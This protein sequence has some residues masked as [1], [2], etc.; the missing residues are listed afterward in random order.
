MAKAKAP[1]TLLSSAHAALLRG[2]NVGGKNKLPMKDL[3]ALFTDAGCSDVQTYIQSG[4]VV[5]RAPESGLPGLSSTIEKG[6]FDRF[7]F[8][9]PVIVRAGEILFEVNRNNPFLREGKDPQTLHVAF[10]S[11]LPDATRVDK[12][13]QNRSSPDTFFVLGQHI[14]LCLPNGVA[15]TKLTNDYFDRTLG[16]ISTVRNFRTVQTL[17]EMTAAG[18]Q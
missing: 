11:A 7:G 17:T 13:D 16:V 2:I 5:F 9:S 8:H 10:L 12:L 15:K 4:N 1:A 14:Y 3:A 6:I 18:L